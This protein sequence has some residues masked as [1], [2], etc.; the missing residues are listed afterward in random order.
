MIEA[1]KGSPGLAFEIV[2]CAELYKGYGDTFE[3]SQ[4]N[5][6]DIQ[7]GVIGP[8]LDGKLEASI[9]ADAVA[10]A[11]VAALSDATGGELQKTLKSINQKM[12]AA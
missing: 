12:Q 7:D 4:R 9:A 5:F 3:R 1:A 2:Q 6:A 11:R 10:N 8:A